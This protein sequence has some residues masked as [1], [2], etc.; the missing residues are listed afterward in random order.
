M[1]SRIV[2]LLWSNEHDMWWKTAARGYTHDQAEAGRYSEAEALAY[3]LRSADCGILSQVTCMVAAPDNW[4][5]PK[6]ATK[7]ELVLERKDQ[8]NETPEIGPIMMTPPI[9]EDYWLY[10][11]RLGGKQAIVAFPKFSTIGIG[12]AQ[13]EDWNTNL[14]YT[15]GTEEIYEHIAHNKGDDSISREDCLAAIA[16]VQAAAKE[17]DSR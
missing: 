14:P 11:V 5:A 13:E 7:R 6:A 3:V 15:C 2:Y 1:P 9:D 17:G 12:F 4:T 8:P 16:I 10:R